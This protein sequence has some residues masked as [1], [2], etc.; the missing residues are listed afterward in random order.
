METE[1]GLQVQLAIQ[2]LWV[3]HLCDL[4]F[5]KKGTAENFSW[6]SSGSLLLT[7]AE[8]EA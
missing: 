2:C 6:C 3:S 8:A 1:L 4:R 7:G 5:P